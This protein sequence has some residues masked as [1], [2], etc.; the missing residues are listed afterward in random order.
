MIRALPA[1]L[2]LALVASPALAHHGSLLD[3]VVETL[4]AGTAL[5]MAGL[6]ASLWLR[7]RLARA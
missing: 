5:F 4:L 2:A 3:H 7:R 6:G 1:A